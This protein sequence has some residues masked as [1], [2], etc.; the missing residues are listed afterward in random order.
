[1]DYVFACLKMN[2]LFKKSPENAPFMDDAS[3]ARGMN[4][5]CDLAV[6]C[7]PPIKIPGY[8]P[9]YKQWQILQRSATLYRIVL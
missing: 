9:G 8:V 5:C 6:V 4:K 2:I 3:K 7:P 1:M